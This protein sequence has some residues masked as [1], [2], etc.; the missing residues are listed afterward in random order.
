MKVAFLHLELSGGPVED[1]FKKICRAIIRAAE[2]G[3]KCVV[4]PEVALQGYFFSEKAEKLE[5]VLVPNFSIDFI[6][7]LA[8]N[9]GITI[10]LCC[11]ELDEDTGHY[12]NSCQVIS[13][14]GK[15]ISKQYKMSGHTIGAE[16]WSKKGD[17]FL[18]VQIGELKIG[19]LICC[20]SWYVK[21]AEKARYLDVDLIL[22]P[23]AWNDYDCG[24]GMPEDAWKRCSEVSR[25]P[26]WVCNQTGSSERMDLTSAKSA[27]VMNGKTEL[28]YSGEEA[29][30]MF[31]WDSA[32]NNLASE[33][34]EKFFYKSC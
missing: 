26:V 4:T 25:A 1:N 7:K 33:S 27:I 10:F 15:I 21:N 18:P 34:F 16:A 32:R 19:I 2:E 13:S 30:L 8:K 14:E 28:V 23:A 3:V 6:A 24:G 20:D 17:R 11:A 5:D 22:V 29:L 12:Y 31:D 9:Y